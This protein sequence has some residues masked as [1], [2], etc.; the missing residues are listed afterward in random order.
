MLIQKIYENFSYKIAQLYLI[1]RGIKE[2]TKNEI[3]DL[4]EGKKTFS[5]NPILKELPC[6]VNNMFFYDAKNGVAQWF[7]H[8][9][10]THDERIL[11]VILHKNKQYQWILSEA[12]E[13]YEDYLE[14]SYSYIGF[15]DKNLWPLTDFGNITLPELSAKGFDWF[16]KQAKK[17]KDRP[18]SILNLF[19][20]ISEEFSDLELNNKLNKN[21]KFIIIFIEN[22]RHI[23]VHRSGSVKDKHVFIENTLKKTGLYN[24]GKYDQNIFKLIE[25]FF[26]KNEFKNLIVLI[27]SERNEEHF[28]LI[29]FDPLD[30][31]LN[32]L[33][34]SSHMVFELVNEMIPTSDQQD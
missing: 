2:T 3:T 4:T 13:A 24:N 19:R 6:S 5:K 15:N 10:S 8:K 1:W 30:Y 7:G 25:L 31:L 14:E 21:L 11:E 28:T 29:D 12:Y 26:G 33:M 34:A 27:E 16:L 9:T 32:P 20:N 23:I 18:Y 22:L 17:K